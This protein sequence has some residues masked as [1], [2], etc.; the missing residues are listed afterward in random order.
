MHIEKKYSGQIL[1]YIPLR[2][3]PIFLCQS[4]FLQLQR[5]VMLGRITQVWSPSR[6]DLAHSILSDHLRYT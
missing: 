1:L 3:L 5:L 2:W 4:E 6:D